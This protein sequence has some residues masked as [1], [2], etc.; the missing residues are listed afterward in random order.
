VRPELEKLKSRDAE[1]LRGHCRAF[2]RQVE[3]LAR[4]ARGA[5]TQVAQEPQETFETAIVDR[6]RKG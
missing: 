2:A 1:A 5:G 6:L 4:A 3:M